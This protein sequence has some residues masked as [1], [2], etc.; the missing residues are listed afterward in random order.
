[1]GTSR[2]QRAAGYVLLTVGLLAL[3]YSIWLGG[4]LIAIQRGAGVVATDSGTGVF[5]LIYAALP[6]AVA[7]LSLSHLIA[8]RPWRPSGIALTAFAFLLALIQLLW[9]IDLAARASREVIP[10]AIATSLVVVGVG[11]ATWR[12]STRLVSASRSGATGR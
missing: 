12:S 10:F 7:C 9:L 2:F 3:A 4:L 8:R 6:V 1:M 5:L 11:F